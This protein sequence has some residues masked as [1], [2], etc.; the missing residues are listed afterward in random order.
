MTGLSIRG[1]GNPNEAFPDLKHEV[2]CELAPRFA[3]P[4]DSR[5][6]SKFGVRKVSGPFPARKL[7]R[8]LLKSLG[9]NGGAGSRTLHYF[10][11]KHYAEQDLSL[12]E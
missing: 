2:W 3:F 11:Q 4:V 9:K 7:M 5:K 12:H 8:K 10:E 1:T 6:P